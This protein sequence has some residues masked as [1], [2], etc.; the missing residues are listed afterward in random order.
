VQYRG[1]GESEGVE[2]QQVKERLKQEYSRGLRRTLK[3]EL[4][5]RNTITAVGALADRAEIQFWYN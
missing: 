4:N 5:A 1:V 2:H 3:C